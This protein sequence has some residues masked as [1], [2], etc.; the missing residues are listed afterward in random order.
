MQQIPFESEMRKRKK[1]QKSTITKDNVYWWR[2][3]HWTRNKIVV[4]F[5]VAFIFHV[6]IIIV[7]IDDDN[8]DDSGSMSENI[9]VCMYLCAFVSGNHFVMTQIVLFLQTH[10]YTHYNPIFIFCGLKRLFF[11][12]GTRHW[13]LFTMPWQKKKYENLKSMVNY[14]IH[15]THTHK[16]NTILKKKITYDYRFW[17]YILQWWWLC[18]NRW[19]H[20]VLP[21]TVSLSLF[22]YISHITKFK[23]MTA[24]KKRK[25]N[26]PW[27]L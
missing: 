11:T 23:V 19:T 17:F 16:K 21:I 25:H 2:Q 20:H 22:M 12:S 3:L 8:N 27:L 18:L 1:K 4:F 14:T 15:W 13:I 5:F 7:I 24:W 9:Y 26:V 6:R 10:T